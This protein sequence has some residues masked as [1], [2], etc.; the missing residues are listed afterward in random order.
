MFRHP[1][2]SLSKHGTHECNTLGFNT[3]ER[4]AREFNTFP[5]MLVRALVW[6]LGLVDLVEN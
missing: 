3:H 2:L 1:R 4:N 6:L 5:P